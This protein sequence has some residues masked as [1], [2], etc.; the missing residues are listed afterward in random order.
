MVHLV[1]LFMKTH[2][3]ALL[4]DNCFALLCCAFMSKLSGCVRNITA[5]CQHPPRLIESAIL[6]NTDIS[7]KPKY[8]LIIS[9]RPIY[10]SISNKNHKIRN[11]P[12][13]FSYMQ[14]KPL[15]LQMNLT[16]N[17]TPESCIVSIA[18]MKSYFTNLV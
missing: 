8:W 12:A 5:F 17:N 9:A 2:L 16:L 4:Q 10:Q 1:Y 11:T 18:I 6:A 13:N 3:L 15:I 7:A 14:G